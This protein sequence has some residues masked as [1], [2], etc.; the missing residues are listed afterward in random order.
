MKNYKEIDGWFNYEN[1]FDFLISKADDKGIFV[2]CGSWLGK[3]SSY[4][5]DNN[6]KNLD[7]YIIDNWSGSINELDSTQK[8]AKQNDIYTTFLANMGTRKYTSIKSDGRIAANL[9]KDKS[10]EVVF[11]DMEHTYEAVKNDINCWLPKVKIGGYIAGHDYLGGWPGV[12][13]AVD[14][15]FGKNNIMVIG[16]CW[17]YKVEQ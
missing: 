12:M 6:N 2:E 5:C 17:L 11:I 16:D 15:I 13:K 4:L 1:V 3:S 14:E 7:I 10:C 9:F 8:L